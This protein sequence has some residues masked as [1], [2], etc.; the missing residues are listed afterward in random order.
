MSEVYYI[1]R[2]LKSQEGPFTLDELRGII[3]SG[4]FRK[5][6][7]VW[8]SGMADWSQAAMA[9]G[10]FQELPPPIPGSEP[11]ASPTIR[12]DSSSPTGPISPP[13]AVK[14]PL[15]AAAT[16]AA[17]IP[18]FAG[19]WRRVLAALLDGLLIIAATGIMTVFA[20]AGLSPNGV[21]EFLALAKQ[22]HQEITY[23]RSGKQKAFNI[24]GT[25]ATRMLFKDLVG[26]L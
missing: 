18:Q 6:H 23:Q 20:T 10:L 7:L 22:L 3:A 9:T 25:T 2:D 14:D 12:Q 26:L 19:F 15:F 1:C 21:I 5:E 16:L 17:P 24:E 11:E 4:A 13:A 8:T